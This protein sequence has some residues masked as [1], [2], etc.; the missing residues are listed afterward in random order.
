M[1][2][3]PG[4]L[5]RSTALR[6]S[7]S[8]ISG[9]FYRITCRIRR[10]SPA[11]TIEALAQRR[12][13]NDQ[14]R[15]IL[16]ELGTSKEGARFI[17]EKVDNMNRAAFHR[18]AFLLNAFTQL[19][20]VD[21]A[22]QLFLPVPYLKV[23]LVGANL[24]L[25]ALAHIGTRRHFRALLAGPAALPPKRRWFGLRTNKRYNKAVKKQSRPYGRSAWR[26]KTLYQPAYV[27]NALTLFLGSQFIISPER[28][29]FPLGFIVDKLT[30]LATTLVLVFD[31]WRVIRA[32]DDAR[33][34]REKQVMVYRDLDI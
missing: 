17:D 2:T 27:V 5:L 6:S 24:L 29:I 18:F 12:P 33:R 7:L 30:G 3:D 25:A 1:D 8:R 34:A 10:G 15:L 23:V 13:L 20:F 9:L 19:L 21:L 11:E 28:L 32:G 4:K 16:G 14:Q 26:E 22:A 31:V